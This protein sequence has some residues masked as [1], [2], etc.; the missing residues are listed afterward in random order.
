[1]LPPFMETQALAGTYLKGSTICNFAYVLALPKGQV[2]G[3]SGLLLL[4][5][6]EP[7][8]RLILAMIVFH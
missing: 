4:T 7:W 6:P 5:G 3:N 1:M 8:A 2:K